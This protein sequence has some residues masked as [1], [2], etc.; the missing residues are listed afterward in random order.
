MSRSAES[1]GGRLLARWRA[2]SGHPGGAWLFSR[3]LARY[4]PYTGTV[5]PRVLLLEPGHCR[6]RM[7]DGR[8]VRNH[9]RSIH[10]VALTNLGEVTGGLAT[11][12]ALPDTVRGIVIALET[13]YHK[14]ARGTL[15]AE[16]RCS[17]P[18]VRDLLDFE[19][20]TRITDASGDVVAVTTTRWRLAPR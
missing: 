7:R 17:P 9:L 20:E 15:T 18:P 11:L 3:V 14:K 19:V 4:V 6:V 16:A 5:R 1:P 10:A 13:R 2:W 8:R 12:T